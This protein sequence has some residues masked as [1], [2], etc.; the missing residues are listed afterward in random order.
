MSKYYHVTC[1]S[2]RES[3]KKNGLVIG[4][5]KGLDEGEYGNGPQ[6]I[7]FVKFPIVVWPLSEKAQKDRIS[8]LKVLC[9]VKYMCGEEID[10]WMFKD[11]D[12]IIKPHTI[13]GEYV[14]KDKIEKRIPPE[15]LRL[16]TYPPL[17]KNFSYCDLTTSL[18]TLWMAKQYNAKQRKEIAKYYGIAK[19]DPR[20]LVMAL[21]GFMD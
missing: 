2:N 20:S 8:A 18:D 4:A 10:V 14:I 11:Y 21:S 7:Y 13:K 16:D 19:S 1:T 5:S 6:N 9:H 17:Y 12:N 3:I 15:R